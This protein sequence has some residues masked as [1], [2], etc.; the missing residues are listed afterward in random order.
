MIDDTRIHPETGKTL[1][2]GVRPVTVEY[3]GDAV[4]V[5]QPGWWPVDEDDEDGIFVGEDNAVW[6]EAPNELKRRH[7]GIKAGRAKRARR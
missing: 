1:R 5:E 7:P 2:R 4:I 6:S 3:D